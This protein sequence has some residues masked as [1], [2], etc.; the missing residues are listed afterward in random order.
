VHVAIIIKPNFLNPVLL[1]VYLSIT[2]KLHNYMHLESYVPLFLS[3]R[4]I[5]HEGLRR[6]E[7]TLQ[8]SI[9]LNK[10]VLSSISSCKLLFR[11]LGVVF[12]ISHR[13][14]VIHRVIMLDTRFLS[15]YWTSVLK[16][17][18]VLELD[19]QL[20][21]TLTM[22]VWTIHSKARKYLGSHCYLVLL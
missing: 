1:G 6:D 22:Q 3:C 20:C 19:I 16:S 5:E 14:I 7:E 8:P 13:A 17:V 12:F 2:P 10:Y 21:S 18:F 11:F 15:P 9:Y 4:F